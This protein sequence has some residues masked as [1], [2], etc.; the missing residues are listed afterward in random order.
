MFPCLIK[1]RIAIGILHGH[2]Y[3]A[4]KCPVVLILRD[5]SHVIPGQQQYIRDEN[6]VGHGGALVEAITLN[7]RVVGSTH[8]LA[9][10]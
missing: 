2:V 1:L 5:P 6:M 9:A 3:A 4:S 8:A 10:M 7:R